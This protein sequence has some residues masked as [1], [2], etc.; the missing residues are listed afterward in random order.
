MVKLRLLNSA[1]QRVCSIDASTNSLAFAIFN[2]KE[3]ESFG[4][5]NFEGSTPHKRVADACAKTRDLFKIFKID[6]VVIEQSIYLNSPKTMSDLSM[7]QGAILGGISLSQKIRF[8]SVPPITWQSYIGNGKLT[9]EDKLLIRSD[10]PAKSESWYKNKERER[11][12]EKT[13]RFVNTFY[14]KN[15]SDNDIADAIGIGYYAI[16]NW[17]KLS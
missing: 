12:K 10:N 9:H 16:N 3:L 17:S 4:K 15:I 14:D 11:R 2:N 1:P 6:A 7:L 8:A 5:I 13:I